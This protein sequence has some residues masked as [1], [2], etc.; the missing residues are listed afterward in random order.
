MVKKYRSIPFEACLLEPD[1]GNWKEVCEFIGDTSDYSDS[2]FDTPP[3]FLDIPTE[4]GYDY[5]MA[6]SFICK[7]P[8][9]K[10]EV[11][12]YEQFIETFEEIIN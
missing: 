4:D 1:M 7:D 10:F 2:E 12:T 11:W 6:N 3:D 8:Q 9:G 5:G